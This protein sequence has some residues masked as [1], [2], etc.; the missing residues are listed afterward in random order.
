MGYLWLVLASIS[1]FMFLMA[2][3]EISGNKASFLTIGWFVIFIVTIFEAGTVYKASRHKP[4]RKEQDDAYW[5][6]IDKRRA[7]R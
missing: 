5:A 4:T 3:T 6:A 2:A 7:R 1:I